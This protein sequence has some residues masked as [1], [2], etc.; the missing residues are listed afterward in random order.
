MVD[1]IIADITSTHWW[2]TLI[3]G[4]AIWQ[5]LYSRVLSWL[6]T[7]TIKPRNA[8]TRLLMERSEKRKAKRQRRVKWMQRDEKIFQFCIMRVTLFWQLGTLF[9]FAATIHLF[10]GIPLTTPAHFMAHL[11]GLLFLIIGLELLFRGMELQTDVLKAIKM[12]LSTTVDVPED[13]SAIL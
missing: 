2:I 12:S 11:A 5:F 10:F 13:T 3:I 7:L 8:I 1:S 6:A 4:G 9:L